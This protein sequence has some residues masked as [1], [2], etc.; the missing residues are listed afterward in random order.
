MAEGCSKYPTVV[1]KIGPP[2]TVGLHSQ[3]PGQLLLLL[4]FHHKY[5][6]QGQY[7]QVTFPQE[8][9]S[10]KVNLLKSCLHFAFLLVNSCHE[11]VLALEKCLP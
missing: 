5:L 2:S 7:L 6:K 10:S 11:G 8:Q 1:A 9:V 4:H 3:Y